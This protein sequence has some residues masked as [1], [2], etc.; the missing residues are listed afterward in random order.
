MHISIDAISNMGALVHIK[1]LA[2][3]PPPPP[4]PL[5]ITRV[6]IYIYESVVLTFQYIYSLLVFREWLYINL[7]QFAF[8]VRKG[9]RNKYNNN[10]THTH[11]WL[12]QWWCSSAPNNRWMRRAVFFLVF[13]T[14]RIHNFHPPHPPIHPPPRPRLRVKNTAI[15]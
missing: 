12:Y 14:Q 6:R 8:R 3:P 13:A 9:L 15:R 2:P 10:K 5:Q 4:S 11:C 1:G 7:L